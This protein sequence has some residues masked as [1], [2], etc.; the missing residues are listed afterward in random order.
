MSTNVTIRLATRDDLTQL[1]ALEAACFDYSRIGKRS[2]SRLMQSPSAQLHVLVQAKQI[3]AYSLLLTRRN[4]RRWRLYSLAVAPAARGQGLSKQLLHYVIDYVKAQHASA[5][6][7]EVKTDNAAA[8]ALYRQLNFEVIDVL[9]GYYD[10]GCDGYK[11]SL[12][13]NP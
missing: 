13:F 4:S 6:T 2:F 5:L 1:V 8:I 10:D 11:M 12:S 9:V 7:L 3:Q